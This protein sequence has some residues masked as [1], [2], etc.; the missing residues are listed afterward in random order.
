MYKIFLTV[1]N[2]LAI[3]TKCITS[4][5]RFSELPH[6]IYVYDN[7]TNYKIQ[8]HFMYFSLLYEK[9][10]ISQYTVNTKESTYGAFSKA[11]ACNQFGLNHEQDP[12][13]DKVDFLL[14]LDNDM[15]IMQQGWDKII[16][17]AW[18]DIK[19][20]KM[21]T[22]KV[23]G[24]LPGGISKRNNV[25]VKISGFD[26]KTGINGGSGFWSVRSDFFRDVGYLDIKELVGFDK[27]HDQK[28]WIKLN[29][30]NK[31]KDYILG[32]D[33]KLVLHTGG[34]AGSLCNNLTKYRIS[35]TINKED[36]I[37][38]ERQEE[39]IDALTFDQFYDKIKND[40]IVANNW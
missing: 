22:I 21:D 19:R 35:A 16:K 24:Q 11:A 38:F 2:R 5:K 13:K 14:I 4:L 1:R 34:I 37:K 18:D 25:P 26:A 8:E 39:E 36:V 28:Y 29:N 6:Q 31:G 30:I 20:L 7:S 9:G 40:S 3:T 27:K 12:E 17:N 15:I 32:L 10:L 23:V 33:A